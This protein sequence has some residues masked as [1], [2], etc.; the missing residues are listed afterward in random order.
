MATGS[1]SSSRQVKPRRD[2]N[3]VYDEESFSFMVNRGSGGVQQLA[4][5]SQS[6]VSSEFSGKDIAES[7]NWSNIEFTLLNDTVNNNH[8]ILTREN[9]LYHERLRCEAIENYQ[10]TVSQEGESQ[11]EFVHNTVQVRKNSSTRLDFLEI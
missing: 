5:D 6:S 10:R 1:R 8:Q 9:L 11:Q 7:V 4:T 2:P 3:F